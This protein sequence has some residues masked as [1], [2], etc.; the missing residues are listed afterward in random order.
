MKRRRDPLF[1]AEG[2]DDLL[3]GSRAEGEARYPSSAPSLSIVYQFTIE[4]D[5]R[6]EEAQEAWL[7]MHTSSLTLMAFELKC[8]FTCSQTKGK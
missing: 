2:D 8:N 7:V 6:W 3:F 4:G 1:S 5:E